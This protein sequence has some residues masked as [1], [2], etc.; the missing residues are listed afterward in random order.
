MSRMV[1][2]ESAT[3]KISGGDW[4]LLKKRLTA[5]ETRAM[6]RRGMRADGRGVDALNIGHAKALAYLLDWSLLDTQDKP[7]IIR[8]QP[9][10]VV[11]A[12]LDA[13]DTESFNEIVAAV[14]AHEE[15]M[16]RERDEEK[17]LTIGRTTSETS[18]P[19]VAA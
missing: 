2:P 10:S 4:L 3:A 13:L 15:A 14:V 9:E 5:G 11:G 1:R 16:E 7:I 8:D 19:S 12:A 18:T 6:L 17:K